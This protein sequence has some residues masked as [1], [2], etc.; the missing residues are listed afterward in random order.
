MLTVH[1]KCCW[2]CLLYIQSVAGYA[3]STFKVLLDMLTVPIWELIVGWEVECSLH[4]SS[5]LLLHETRH[6]RLSHQPTRVHNFIH[7]TYKHNIHGRH[8]SHTGHCHQH[9]LASP[10]VTEHYRTHRCSKTDHSSY[11]RV[12]LSISKFTQAKLSDDYS[13]Q[14]QLQI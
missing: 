6:I 7:V 8:I 1:S 12:T 4:C 13:K 2:I 10:R 3:Y 14:K 11:T 9:K 5:S